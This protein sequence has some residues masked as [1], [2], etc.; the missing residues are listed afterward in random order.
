V[1]ASATTNVI[2]RITPDIGVQWPSDSNQSD[3]VVGTRSAT[4]AAILASAH[5]ATDYLSTGCGVSMNSNN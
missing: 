4:S 2:L 1:Q 3:E 5:A